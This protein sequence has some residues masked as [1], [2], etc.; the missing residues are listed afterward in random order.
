MPDKPA[1][2]RREFLGAGAVM[3]STAATVPLFVERS[4]W[5]VAPEPGGDVKEKPGSPGGR[6]LVVIQLTGG[7]D[8][9]NTVVPFGSREYYQARPVIGVAERDVLKLDTNVGIGLHPELA[10]LRAMIEARQAAVVLGVG[11][12]N[13][14]RSHFSSMDIWHTAD[15]TGR[16][17]KG[18]GWLGRSLDEVRATAGGKIDAAACI[19][20]G[21]AAPMATNGRQVKAVTFEDANL[22]R[23]SGTD[24]NAALGREYDRLN[25]AGI[26]GAAEPGSAAAFVMRTA[27]DAQIA[28]DKV[29]AAVAREPITA[30]PNG[31]LAGQLRMVAAMIRAGLPTRVYYVTLGGFDTHAGQPNSHGRTLRGFASAVRSFYAELGALGAQSRVLTMAFSEFGRR[32]EQNASNGT[33]HGTAGPLFLFGDMVRPSRT[34]LLGEYP[35]L[36]SDKLDHGDLIYNTD[37]RSI[38]A[39]VLEDWMKVD[40][41]KVLG[42]PFRAAEVIRKT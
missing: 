39:A 29:R 19:C 3:I 10:D 13:P 25:R 20:I 4:A 7:N 14:N 31:A 30:F 35:S 1:F 36:A 26:V 22:F 37:F 12:P 34:G 23:W 24:L 18:L 2:T 17:G 9:L 28:S 5:A 6:I 32:V 27:L 42:A 41:K 38:Y 8:G 40:V 21:N 16:S 11:Y 33:D 15:P